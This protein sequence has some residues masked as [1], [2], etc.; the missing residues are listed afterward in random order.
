MSNQPS[1]TGPDGVAR[2]YIGGQ[3][4]I[5][6]VMMR[7]PH[8][9]SAVVR[10]KNGTLVVR[11]REMPDT[12]RG[13]KAWPGIRGVITLVEALK[14][15]SGAL[16]F[17]ADIFEQD[18]EEEEQAAAAAKRG[19]S[20]LAALS[21]PILALLTAEP[22]TP[23]AAP[24][25]PKG[26]AKKKL[27]T[28]LAVAFAL[29][30][31]VALPQAFAAGTSRLFGLGLDVRSPG[32]QLI[33]GAGKLVIIIGYMLAIRRMPEI[34]RV[35]QYHGAEHKSI[36]TYEAG[37]AL[38][39]DNARSKTTLHPRCGTTFLVMVALVS[40]IVFTAIGPLLPQLGLGKLVDN[41]AFFAMKLPFLPV[42]AALTFEIQRVF[43]RYCTRGPLRALLWPGFLVQK[44][45]TIEPDDEQLEVAL[46]ALAVALGREQGAA[47]TE[48]PADLTFE[49][50]ALLAEAA[51]SG[52]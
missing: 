37:E 45:T 14:L 42:I 8:S 13:V 48:D 19:P 29:V 25:E 30:L 41:I 15:G 32:F 17:A 35:F 24:E 43:A 44:I 26:D 1:V 46:G 51:V 49:S 47:T 2:P 18:L 50:Y 28:A 39:V 22:G 20:T 36:Y 7:S 21:L 3:A 12:R 4:L 9:F 52:A 11:Q 6:G 31:F 34:Y 10:R 40:I 33:T 27:F 5:E 38:V 16:R 23:L